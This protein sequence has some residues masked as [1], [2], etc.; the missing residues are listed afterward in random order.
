MS[1]VHFR[2]CKTLSNNAKIQATEVIEG[3][4]KNENAE[5]KPSNPNDRRKSM[6]SKNNA[7]DGKTYYLY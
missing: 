7:V 5:E 6:S 1:A 2:K 4:K 3:V